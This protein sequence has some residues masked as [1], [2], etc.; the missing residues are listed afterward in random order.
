MDDARY[1]PTQ[2]APGFANPL[3]VRTRDDARRW[4][5]SVA[6]AT[7]LF[8]DEGL[9]GTRGPGIRR[10][11][12]IYLGAVPLYRCDLQ[13]TDATCGLVWPAAVRAAHG[14]GQPDRRRTRGHPSRHARTLSP[15]LRHVRAQQPI[16]SDASASP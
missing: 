12:S 7:E 1:V 11:E 5:I 15:R 9:P 14:L 8:G 4:Q 6:F 2:E 3:F 16:S 10:S 13:R